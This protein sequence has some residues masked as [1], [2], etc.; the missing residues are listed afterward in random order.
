MR[1]AC[2]PCEAYP[3]VLVWAYRVPCTVCVELRKSLKVLKF[4]KNSVVTHHK[5]GYDW[6]T[7]QADS[8]E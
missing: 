5:D 3:Q 7:G 8:P 2:L 4:E 1:F 6:V